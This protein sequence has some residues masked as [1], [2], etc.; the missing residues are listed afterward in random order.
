ME[1]F[2]IEEFANVINGV[3]KVDNPTVDNLYKKYTSTTVSEEDDGFIGFLKRTH[4]CPFDDNWDITF[5]KCFDYWM[6]SDCNV[7]NQDILYR[8]M[9]IVTKRGG[10]SEQTPDT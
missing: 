1:S 7:W 9:C 6:E 3:E 8:V 2:E 5:K 4:Y 10:E